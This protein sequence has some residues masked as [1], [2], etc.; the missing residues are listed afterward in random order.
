V[1]HPGAA[2]LLTSAANA[3]PTDDG[4]EDRNLAHL[5][6]IEVR[7]TGIG[8]TPPGPDAVTWPGIYGDTLRATI[9]LSAATEPG[10]VPLSDVVAAT[11]ECVQRNA[12]QGWPTVRVLQLRVTGNAEYDGYAGV[13][14]LMPPDDSD[15]DFVALTDENARADLCSRIH[16]VVSPIPG[17]VTEVVDGTFRD[18]IARCDRPG[19]LI[20][21]SGSWTDLAGEPDPAERLVDALTAE[22][23]TEVPQ[24]AA[25]GPDGTQVALARGDALCIIRGR[26]D[27]GDDTDPTGFAGDV[28]Q[29]TV[30]CTGSVEAPGEEEP[31]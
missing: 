5:L 1:A 23:W 24:Y 25:D 26:W 11:V 10:D 27:G 31:R 14:D 28:Y 21:V 4:A 13:Y 7:L 3:V 18:D 22:G 6:G 9:D 2:V 12:A 20:V 19:C 16:A 15:A 30:L 8:R 29:V 17:T